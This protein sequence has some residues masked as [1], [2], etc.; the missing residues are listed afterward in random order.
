WGAVH[1]GAQVVENAIVPKGYQPKGIA[2]AVRVCVTF[3]FVM[4]AWVFFR[5]NSISEAFYAFGNIF[6]GITDVREYV[7]DNGYR[8]FG[9]PLA[10]KVSAFLSI[11]ALCLWDWASL[12]RD[13]II[14]V[15]LK[16]SSVLRYAFYFVLLT[17][18]LVMRAIDTTDFVYFQF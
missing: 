7:A 2:R 5:A 4:M 9:I 3:V 18:L 16:K 14:S 15:T 17:A 13:V 6:T 10:D 11:L 8:V 1:G 12:K